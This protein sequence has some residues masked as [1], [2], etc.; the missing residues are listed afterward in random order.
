MDFAV[1]IR[2]DESTGDI[3]VELSDGTVR[4]YEKA[5]FRQLGKQQDL[6]FDPDTFTGQ[7][8]DSFK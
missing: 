4:N 2:I 6:E 8:T 5:P 1:H 3:S 7:C